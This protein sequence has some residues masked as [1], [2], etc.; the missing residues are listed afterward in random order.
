MSTAC[1]NAGL[2]ALIEGREVAK[3]GNSGRGAHAA[4]LADPRGL[5]GEGLAHDG[6]AL[7]E[8]LEAGEG[9]AARGGDSLLLL[10]G[11]GGSGRA[12][13][14]RGREGTEGGGRGLLEKRAHGLGLAEDGV[15][16]GSVVVAKEILC[17]RRV[18]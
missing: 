6:T 15:H 11:C 12:A 5:D 2:A 9:A 3:T 16:G 13:T 17:C 18:S 7:A 10:D 14:G 4:S 8:Q 1:V